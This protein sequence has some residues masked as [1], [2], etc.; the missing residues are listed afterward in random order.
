MQVGSVEWLI[1]HVEWFD[2]GDYNIRRGAQLGTALP[3]EEPGDYRVCFNLREAIGHD[4][5]QTT[6]FFEDE[7][8]DFN[9]LHYIAG[10]T[11]E[12]AL[13]MASLIVLIKAYG[14]PREP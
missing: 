3:T 1:N 13:H 9:C 11:S 10:C 5:Y 12:T 4:S 14:W 6:Y 7:P 2:G 8:E